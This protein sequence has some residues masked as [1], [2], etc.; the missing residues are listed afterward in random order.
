MATCKQC[1]CAQYGNTAGT[2]DVAGQSPAGALPASPQATCTCEVGVRGLAARQPLGLSRR[3]DP[4][5]DRSRL[6][7][8]QRLTQ[9]L[10]GWAR[11]ES[12]RGERPQRSHIASM[13]Y[14][15]R[16]PTP[17]SAPAQ[18]ASKA[19]NRGAPAVPMPHARTQP[20]QP[21]RPM[22]RPS[23]GG[24]QAHPA[25]QA[26]KAHVQA[27]HGG[28]APRPYLLDIYGPACAEEHLQRRLVACCQE[29]RSD[30]GR[31]QVQSGK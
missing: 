22:S 21:Q 1:T 28:H 26:P 6:L 25:H 13:G 27:Q 5:V 3:R 24:A 17:Y 9:Q 16:A 12:D 31:R 11:V 4:N 18:P 10:R 19:L 20:T 14:Q 8:P 30:E 29:L 23:P 2:T 15:A 7:Q